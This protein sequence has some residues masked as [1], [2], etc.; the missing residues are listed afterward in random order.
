MAED[1]LHGGVDTS[2]KSLLHFGHV[3]RSR[4]LEVPLLEWLAMP[5][6]IFLM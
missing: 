3:T 6:D 2:D 1:S 4:G 5:L